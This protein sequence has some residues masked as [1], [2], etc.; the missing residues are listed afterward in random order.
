MQP[1]VQAVVQGQ[2]GAVAPPL[3][4]RGPPSSGCIDRGGVGD[5]V[6]LELSWLAHLPSV[7]REFN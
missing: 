4:C 1:G 6:S 2:T 3:C 5:R 7:S